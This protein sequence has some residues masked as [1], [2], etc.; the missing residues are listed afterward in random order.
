VRVIPFSGDTQTAVSEI[1]RLWPRLRG[2]TIRV[3]TPSAVAPNLREPAQPPE[4]PSKDVPRVAQKPQKP[5][6]TKPAESPP[7]ENPPAESPPAQSP[8]A[9]TKPA[10]NPPPENP[11]A[12]GPPSEGEASEEDKKPAEES[13]KPAEAPQKPPPESSS[14]Y[15]AGSA[16]IV[17][18]TCAAEESKP[19]AQPD[20][21][22]EAAQANQEKPKADTAQ[23]QPPD[24]PAPESAKQDSDPEKAKP[25][26]AGSPIM[27][28]PGKGSI[29]IASDD[30]EAL[31]QLQA[32]LESMSPRA[33][34]GSRNFIVFA[35][36][37]T[38]AA[39]VAE[40]LQRL[41]RT[42]QTGWRRGIGSVVVVPDERM[43]TVMVKAS[44]SDRATI[45][46]LLK[47]L[48]SAELPETLPGRKPKLVPLKNTEASRVE[49]VIREVFKSQLTPTAGQASSKS[50]VDFSPQVTVDEVTNSLVVMA[51]TPL[52][53]QITQLAASLDEAAGKN[54]AVELKIIALKNANAL[55]VEKALDTIIKDAV[56]R[57]QH[58]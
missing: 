9:E 26:K 28:V 31:D 12:K 46:G 54:P 1:R 7:A 3:V 11:P 57:R 35:L 43:N 22:K 17:T 20:V 33:G 13:P 16:V 47:V 21:P 36:Q 39:R 30:E 25:P 44:R 23:E 58:R 6:E 27:I 48:D 45:E 38:S 55:R 53:D 41:F 29:T 4:A 49:E 50:S 24:K 18:H 56:F 10:E 34:S 37:N 14:L 51:P 42:D 32:L 52:A 40:T 19:A 15:P 5:A 2:N 8:P